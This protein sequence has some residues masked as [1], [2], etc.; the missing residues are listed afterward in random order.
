VFPK[1]WIFMYRLS[2]YTYLV[3]G[4]L[5][6]GLSNT[7]VQCTDKEFLT[8]NPSS[9]ETCGAYM[10]TYM[11]QFGGYLKDINATTECKFCVIRDTNTFLASVSS[12][13][14]HRWR[15]FGILFAFVIANVGAAV[16]LYYLA[17]VPKTKKEEKE[18]K[19]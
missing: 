9:G 16:L 13:Y 4:L 19:D 18:K 14:G 11:S 10:S 12:S 17:R 15:N 2:P 6:V 3:D 1:F 7:L 8:F 5:G